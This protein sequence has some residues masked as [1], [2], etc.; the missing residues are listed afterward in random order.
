MEKWIRDAL[1]TE[2]QAPITRSEQNA[3]IFAVAGGGKTR[4]MVYMILNDL[5]EGVPPSEI[6]A[7]TFTEKAADE[8]LTRVH[9]A[10]NQHL[11]DIDLAGISIGTIHNWSFE[12][13]LDQDD[14]YNFDPIDELH[15]DALV[16]RIY[17][18]INLESAYGLSF[19]RAVTPFMEDVELFYNENLNLDQVPDEKQNAIR[20]FLNLVDRNRILPFG[21]MI[22]NATEHLAQNGPLENLSRLYVDEYQDVNPAQ[23]ALIKNMLPENGELVAVGD[24]MQCIYQWRGSDVNRILDFEEDFPHSTTF[25]METNYRS[26]PGILDTANTISSHMTSA[27]TDKELRPNRSPTN[28]SAVQWLSYSSPKEQAT[29]IADIVDNCLDNGVDQDEIAVLIRKHSHASSIIETLESR[30]HN[31]VSPALRR[32]TEFINEFVKPVI[33]WLSEDHHEPRNRIEQQ[34]LEAKAEELENS[35]EFWIDVPD[36]NSLDVFWD[37][38]IEWEDAIEDQLNEAYNIRAQLYKL[39]DKCGVKIDH[40]D[41][42]L[43]MGIAITSQIIRSVEEVHRRRLDTDSRRTPRSVMKELYFALER[44]QDDFGETTEIELPQGGVTVTTIHQAKGLEWPIVV[45]PSLN[46]HDLPV[47]TRSHGTSFPDEIADRYGTKESDERRLFYVAATRAE[48]RLFLMDT[49][50]GAPENR[51]PFLE[52]I[53]SEIG[54]EP[55]TLDEIEQRTWQQDWDREDDGDEPVLVGLSDLLLYLECPYQF[56][57]RRQVN[58]E[59]S[60]GDELGYGEGLHELIQRRSEA[61]TSWDD[62]EITERTEEH[63]HLPYMSKPMEDNSIEG[64]E[65]RM[66]TLEEL[67]VFDGEAETEIP[68][69]VVF[70]NGVVHGEI[71]YIEHIDDG[72]LVR[73]WKSNLTHEELIPRYERQLRFYAHV[74]RKQGHDIAR[75]ELVDVGATNEVD[76][77]VRREVDVSNPSIDRLVEEIDDALLN[78]RKEEF[79]PTP[80]ETVCSSCDMEQLCPYSEAPE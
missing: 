14:F 8:L 13:L 55:T 26:R 79:G 29:A 3:N 30:D 24:D 70:E 64:I 38:I 73:D 65:D 49:S 10:A 61:E 40:D 5:A 68:V 35:V 52:E 28:A 59:P 80:S 62:E 21:A 11:G 51:S 60:I 17:D 4:T 20:S 1:S 53:E 78:I 32:G 76:Q 44:N 23:V 7:F 58:I 12:Y 47:P 42:D 9:L 22:R 50:R 43:M 57:L 63:V 16:S 37:A 33:N 41:S 74:L 34:E 19:P 31:V 39:L 27:K 18:E 77:L 45:I 2:Q 69:D 15:A 54:S 75:G 67:D 46:Q 25:V 56:G 6:V 36:D 71:D 66:H 48:D 72:V